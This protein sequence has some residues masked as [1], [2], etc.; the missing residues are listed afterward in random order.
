MSTQRQTFLRKVLTFTVTVLLL[1]ATT[2]KSEVLSDGTLTT[3]SPSF[4]NS[5][6][7]VQTVNSTTDQSKVQLSVRPCGDE[8]EKYCLNDGK[9]IYPQDS[10]RPSCI[11]MP[12]HSGP[13]CEIFTDLTYRPLT[14]DKV[15]PIFFGCVMIFI[16]LGLVFCC[17]IK[18]RCIKS[19]PLIKAAESETSV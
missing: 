3:V 12:S 19:A 5:S 14:V 15:I 18:K 4:L 1:L 8:N 11:C 7:T 13:R 16:I 9:C 10:R 6:L 17:I 2:G